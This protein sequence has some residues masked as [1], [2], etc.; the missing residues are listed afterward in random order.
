[1]KKIKQC[2]IVQKLQYKKHNTKNKI[3]CSFEDDN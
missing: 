1:M 3:W 2:Y